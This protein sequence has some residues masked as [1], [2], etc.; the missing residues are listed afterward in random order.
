MVEF[1][2]QIIR[3]DIMGPFPRSPN[4]FTFLLVVADWYTKYTLLHPMRTATASNVVK[5]VENNVFLVFGVPQF[6]IADNGSQF[7]G[8]KFKQLVDKYQ[9][10]KI[11]FNAVYHPQCNFIERINRTIGTSIRSYIVEHKEWDRNLFSIQQAINTAKHESTGY[12]PAFLNFARYVLTSGKFY[13]EI[14]STE[15]MS[16]L[17]KDRKELVSDFS[18]LQEIFLDVKKR[19]NKAYSK[20]VK[21][22]DLRKRNEKFSLGDKVWRKNKVLSDASVKFLAKLAPKYVL[23]VVR[24]CISNTVYELADVGSD[25]VG[26]WHIKDLKP[27]FGSNSDISVG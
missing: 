5:F 27:Y 19:L 4:G 10:Q 1:P 11:W 17:P 9:V 12:A 24:K 21:Y 14:D 2:W 13:G 18:E 25:Y 8:M 16:L 20:N 23:S 15:G 22:Y 7:A 26:T 3:V 6:I